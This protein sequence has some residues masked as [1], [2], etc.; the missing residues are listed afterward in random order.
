MVTVVDADNAPVAG[1]TVSLRTTLPKGS[2]TASGATGSDGKLTGTYTSTVT[3]A[4]HASHTYD[5][6]ANVETSQ[7]PAVP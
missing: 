6:S 4:S 1:A 2:A 5:P 7:S 3:G